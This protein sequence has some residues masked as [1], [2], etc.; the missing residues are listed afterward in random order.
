MHEAPEMKLSLLL[1][2]SVESDIRFSNIMEGNA[3]LHNV[4]LTALY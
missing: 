2:G 4:T 3:K 1:L